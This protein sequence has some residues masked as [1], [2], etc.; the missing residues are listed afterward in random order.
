MI[1]WY[2][3]YY[4]A[5]ASSAQAA[6]FIGGLPDGS[7]SSRIAQFKNDAWSSL[8]N[9]AA[10]RLGHGAITVGAETMILG[11]YIEIESGP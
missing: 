10:A 11:G 9:L 5:T 7:Y 1:T 2:F 4:Y 6:Y 8:G 3:S